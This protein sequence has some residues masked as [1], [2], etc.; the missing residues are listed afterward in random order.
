L[1]EK[2]RDNL[3]KVKIYL[4]KL[5]KQL[6]PLSPTTRDI[7]PKIK[8]GL[9]SVSIPELFD[10]SPKQSL[11]QSQLND[12]LFSRM[13]RN[14]AFITNKQALTGSSLPAFS[15]FTEAA[16]TQQVESKTKFEKLKRKS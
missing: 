9:S 16:L 11:S 14:R 3:Y 6:Q 4:N 12:Q 10:R 2:Y 13:S 15:I 5:S 1:A 7:K 8:T